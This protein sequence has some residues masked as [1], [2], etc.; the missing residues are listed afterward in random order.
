MLKYKMRASWREF[1]SL[2]AATSKSESHLLAASSLARLAFEK[3][4]LVR[5]SL[6]VSSVSLHRR[7]KTR[8]RSLPKPF[9]QLVAVVAFDYHHSCKAA[10]AFCYYCCCVS[11]LLA[12]D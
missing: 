7:L 4:V 5:S 12:K 10:C 3:K 11:V 6:H 1:L 9:R 8:I 2:N